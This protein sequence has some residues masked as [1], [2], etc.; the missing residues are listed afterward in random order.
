MSGSNLGGAT[1]VVLDG[2]AAAILS[3]SAGSITVES[4]AHFPPG[5]GPISVTTGGGTAAGPTT[6]T[7]FQA[8]GTSWSQ[9]PG[10]A[11][12]VAT[13]GGALFALG[14]NSVSGGYGVW[15]WNGSGWNAFPGGL[16]SLAVDPTGN[17][18]GVNSAQ[19]I[20]QFASGSWH[21]LPGS[22]HQVAVGSGG[23]V[24]V[25][26]TNAVPGG[27]GLWKLSGGAWTQLPG[28]GTSLAVGPGDQPWVVNSSSQIYSYSGGWV[29]E[30]GSATGIG[31]M[32]D[33]VW[34][35][36]TDMTAAGGGIWYFN[37]AGWSN[38]SGDATALAVG[39]DTLP[40]AVNAQ[41]QIWRR[42]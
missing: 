21:Q 20:Y 3:D 1:S 9:L 39:G 13:G 11:H 16:V 18:W 40:I 38:L 36:G 35:V 24:F 37:G 31:A 29:L 22:A 12:Q 6:Y 28:G 17:P 8:T 30:P 34:V 42:S 10:S 23:S 5:S 4:G 32:A 2:A 41:N 19:Q 26:G 15:Q 25:L 27:W 33:S 7:Y 14:T